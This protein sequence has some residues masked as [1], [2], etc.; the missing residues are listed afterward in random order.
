MHACSTHAHQ[1]DPITRDFLLL[2]LQKRRAIGN[3]KQSRVC[4]VVADKN[5]APSPLAL[6]LCAKVQRVAFELKRFD[7]LLVGSSVRKGRGNVI[8]TNGPSHYRL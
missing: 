5:S 2:P 4:A 1:F 7:Y 8:A 3:R 6:Y